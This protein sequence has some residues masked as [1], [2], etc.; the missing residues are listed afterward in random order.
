[1]SGCA[2]HKACHCIPVCRS[3]RAPVSVFPLD[4]QR[5]KSMFLCRS[6]G[7]F[8]EAVRLLAR[9]STPRLS[10]NV[11]AAKKFPDPPFL[12]TKCSFPAAFTLNRRLARKHPLSQRSRVQRPGRT[13]LVDAEADPTKARSTSLTIMNSVGPS[14]SPNRLRQQVHRS[15][16]F[17]QAGAAHEHHPHF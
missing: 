11:S 4:W 13:G 7:N 1:M 15:S 14:C 17:F 16:V 10:A 2:A 5:H 6:C 8:T 9:I 12:M 3:A